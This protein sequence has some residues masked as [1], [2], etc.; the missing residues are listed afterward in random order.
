MRM[1]TATRVRVHSS[2]RSPGWR[3]APER[4]GASCAGP[5]HPRTD[6]ALADTQGLGDPALRPALL[7]EVPSLQAPSVFPIVRCR[8]H[9][10]ESTIAPP[11][12]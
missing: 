1:M 11:E 7:F 10:E 8:V 5:W 2:P 3:P 12:F 6:G 4:L 9:P